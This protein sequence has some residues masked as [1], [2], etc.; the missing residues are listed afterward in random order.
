MLVASKFAWVPHVKLPVSCL[1]YSGNFTCACRQFACILR[2]VLAASTQ[3]NLPVFTGKLH[4]TQV[5]CAWELFTCELQVKLP[6]FAGVFARASFTVYL[7]FLGALS[8][9]HWLAFS[10][11]ETSLW[12]SAA[13]HKIRMKIQETRCVSTSQTASNAPVPLFRDTFGFNCSDDLSLG[14]SWRFCYWTFVSSAGFFR[15]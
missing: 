10:D 6:E 7:C 13:S 9:K 11:S 8:L 4:L 12:L 2:E 3:V 14:N 1:W 5:N 15:F